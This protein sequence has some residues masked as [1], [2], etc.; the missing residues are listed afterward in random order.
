MD[1]R[2]YL[3]EHVGVTKNREDQ[4][5]WEVLEDEH[6]LE[7]KLNSYEKAYKRAI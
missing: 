4:I 7:R 5:L 6:Y 3:K 1:I 2:T